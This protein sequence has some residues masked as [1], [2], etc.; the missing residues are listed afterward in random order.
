MKQLQYPIDSIFLGFSRKKKNL[1]LWFPPVFLIAVHINWCKL[2]CD[3]PK[4]TCSLLMAISVSP[5]R[6]GWAQPWQASEVPAHTE[7][8]EVWGLS[9]AHNLFLGFYVIGFL[10]MFA[11]PWISKKGTGWPCCHAAW[12]TIPE[13]GH[14]LWFLSP[15]QRHR[16]KQPLRISS[17]YKP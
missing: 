6:V 5:S 15:H 13:A 10:L 2:G 16:S 4:E 8:L 7:S 14:S 12:L 3:S 9:S 11:G 17:Q 1:N